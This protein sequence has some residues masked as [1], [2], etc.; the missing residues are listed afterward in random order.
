MWTRQRRSGRLARLKT[1]A[2][3]ARLIKSLAAAA[4]SMIIFTDTANAQFIGQLGQGCSY[5]GVK[6]IEA[7][8]NAAKENRGQISDTAQFERSFLGKLQQIVYEADQVIRKEYLQQMKNVVSVGQV[9]TDYFVPRF[10]GTKPITDGSNGF[11][12]ASTGLL[13]AIHAMEVTKFQ[14]C[15]P[16]TWKTLN[17]YHDLLSEQAKLELQLQFQR[18]AYE[19]SGVV[20]VVATQRN[21]TGK[22]FSVSFWNCKFYNK[23]GQPV[24]YAPITFHNIP[25]GAFIV[26]SK[27]VAIGGMFQDADCTLTYTED[28]TWENEKIYFPVYQRQIFGLDGEE[29]FPMWSFQRKIHGRAK[30]LSVEE[31]KEIAKN[32]PQWVGHKPGYRW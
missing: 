18:W 26:E 27:T 3:A 29:S 32:L 5:F 21:P 8:E 7:V 24:G 4:V 17:E 13:Q 28:V 1:L 31:S 10:E 9:V 25:W 15:F 6:I 23:E 22:P 19:S 12:G 16:E 11:S 20:S 2:V 14:Q 30:V